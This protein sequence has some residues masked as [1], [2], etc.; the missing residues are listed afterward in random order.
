M[1]R[2]DVFERCRASPDRARSLFTVLAAI[3]LARPVLAPLLL[4]LSLMCSYWRSR[5]ALH[6]LWG[7]SHTT[8]SLF[9]TLHRSRP[10]SRANGSRFRPSGSG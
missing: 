3:S 8:L 7:M 9:V 10:F 1:S 4:A 6:A 5:L 2:V